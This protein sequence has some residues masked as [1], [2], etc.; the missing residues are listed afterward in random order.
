MVWGLLGP[1]GGKNGHWL[2]KGRALTVQDEETS[3]IS[4]VTME[5]FNTTELCTLK[6]EEQF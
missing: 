3:K 6:G 4:C 1:G 5:I 2:S